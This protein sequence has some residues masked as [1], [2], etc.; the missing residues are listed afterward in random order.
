[1]FSLFKLKSDKNIA[2]SV[3]V[4]SEATD[5]SKMSDAKQQLFMQLKAKRNELGPEEIA[6]MQKAVE[7]QALQQKIKNDIDNGGDKLDRL[8]D[9]IRFQMSDRQ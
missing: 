6:R 5:I 8:L 2:P 1:M 7:M 4:D 9:E 3:P